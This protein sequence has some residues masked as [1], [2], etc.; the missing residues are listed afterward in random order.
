M[1]GASDDKGRDGSEKRS[2]KKAIVD[3]DDIFIS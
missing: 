2:P 1:L 3:F